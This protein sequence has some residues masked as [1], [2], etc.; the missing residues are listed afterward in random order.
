MEL[1]KDI[2]DIL[3]NHPYQLTGWS[4]RK[5]INALSLTVLSFGVAEHLMSWY[6]FIHDRLVQV[7]KCHWDIGSWP[8]YIVTTHLSQ[9]YDVLPTNTFTVI[10]SEYMNIAFTFAWT[11]ADVFIMVMSISIA[12]KFRTIN[13]RLEMFKERVS[14]FEA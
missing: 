9:I 3:N 6:S 12:I 7:E 5:R 13:D 4:L 8:Y 1:F 14:H 2:E 10:W 11:F